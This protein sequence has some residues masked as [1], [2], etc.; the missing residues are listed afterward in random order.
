[1]T[2]TR[3]EGI[4]ELG[5]A[6]RACGR[7]RVI[8]GGSKPALHVAEGELIELGGVSGV[9]EYDPSEYTITALAGTPIR[10]V[11]AALEAKG[12]YLPFD[13]PWVAAGATLGG[14]VAAG[15]VGPGRFRYGGVRDFLI[16]VRLFD[17]EGKLV[18]GGGKVVK[19]AA[20]FDLPKLMVGALGTLGVLA[21]LSFKVFPR[22][23][24]TRTLHVAC[25][26]PRVAVERLARA[27]GSRWC[28]ESLEY[29]AD[30]G[31]LVLRLGAP[32]EALDALEAEIGGEWSG[33]TRRGDERFWDDAREIAW[34]GSGVL[35]KVPL[36]PSQIVVV[37]S[38]IEGVDGIRRRYGSGGNLAWLAVPESSREVLD[39]TLT[40]LGLRG[41]AMRGAGPR[42]LGARPEAAIH[43]AVKRAMDPAGRFPEL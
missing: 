39:R 26:S 36:A 21:E 34:A 18:R 25:A 13:P 15:A 5:E 28:L 43:G 19:N 20:G 30:E 2:A 33:E 38:R 35:V 23:P 31:E 11:E 24:A 22:P 17:G 40:E 3:P 32:G 10:E 37:D 1:M 8:G 29:L 9:V 4:E 6:L 16:G 42:W 27:A 41:L 14:T 7:V 12:Q